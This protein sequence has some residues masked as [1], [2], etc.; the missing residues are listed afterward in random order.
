MRRRQQS[1]AN[2][3]TFQM[4]QYLLG[5]PLFKTVTDRNKIPTKWKKKMNLEKEYS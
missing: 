2:W 4:I 1:N 5:L 3:L